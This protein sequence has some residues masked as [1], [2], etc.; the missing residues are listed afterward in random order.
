[1][2]NRRNFIKTSGTIAAGVTVASMIPGTVSCANKANKKIVVGAIGVNGMGF[3]D[4]RSMLLQ[5]NVECAMICDVDESVLAK[6][7]PQITEL[8]NGVEPKT[9]GN[10]KEVLENKDI[11]AVIIGT[12]DHWH[13]LIMIEACQAGKHVYVEKPMAN[14]IYEAFQMEKAARK[15]KRVVQ[16]GQWQRSDPH[17]NAVF[18]FVQSGQL[19]EIR[20]V[21]V[22][23]YLDWITPPPVVEDTDVP[24][25]VDYDMWLG[26]APKRPF[27]KNRFHFHFRWFWD[28][29][30]GLMTDWGVHLLDMAL[31]GMD[32]DLP[33]T[34]M[35]SGGKLA[36]P[37]SAIE[38]PD[39]Q[40][41]IYEYGN[42]NV[43]WDHAMGI[44]LGDWKREH[45]LAFIGN[46][47]TLVVDRGGWEVFPEGRQEAKMEAVPRQQGTGQGLSLHTANFLDGIRNN[48]RKTTANPTIARAVACMSHMGNIALKTGSKIYWDADK[49][50]FVGNDEANKL[51]TPTYRDPWVLPKV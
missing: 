2:T 4:L 49:Q 27:N 1:M 10:Y 23:T 38:T 21:K 28:Y 3:S 50:L 12:P 8:N 20:T 32:V 34:A 35:S 36:F 51:I 33:K 29:A 24:D 5:E 48:D 41:V 15:Y 17:W 16:V 40:Q 26:P 30:G 9:T 6:R 47:G 18:D 45:G 22:W 19:G 25:G 42:F 39:T 37:D 44:G 13:A 7:L 46:N 11:D 14:S 43:I 31:A